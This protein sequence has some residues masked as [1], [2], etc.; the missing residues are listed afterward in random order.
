MKIGI[1]GIGRIHTPES[2][3]KISAARKATLA[4]KR[5]IN[6]KNSV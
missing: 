4:K 5:E 2:K 1:S 6:I 3:A